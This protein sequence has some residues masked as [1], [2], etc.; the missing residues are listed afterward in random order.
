MRARLDGFHTKTRP[1][2]ELFARMEL[3]INVDG[4]ATVEAVQAEIRRRLKF[5]D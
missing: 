1:V 3:V 5:S 4:T 2:L